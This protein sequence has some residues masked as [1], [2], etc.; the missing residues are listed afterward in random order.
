VSWEDALLTIAVAIQSAYRRPQAACCRP[1]VRRSI[2]ER[3]SRCPPL[4]L[5]RIL[6]AASWD[7]RRVQFLSVN[8][9]VATIA[10]WSRG[11]NVP[12]ATT[13]RRLPR[14]RSFLPADVSLTVSVSLPPE[15][16]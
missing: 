14:L 5:P 8:V 1:R 9:V 15:K 10:V 4:S 11:V 12:R 13:F 2:P 6:R 3:S 16:L 7:E